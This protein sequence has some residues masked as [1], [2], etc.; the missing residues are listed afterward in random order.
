MPG[1]EG[2]GGIIKNWKQTH[3]PRVGYWEAAKWVA[4]L[5]DRKL[6]DNIIIFKTNMSFGHAGASG[7]F[8]YLKEAADDLVF[9][10]NIFKVK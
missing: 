3:I 1:R 10:T 5:R 6:G 9:I 4:R 7:R 2:G 8:D